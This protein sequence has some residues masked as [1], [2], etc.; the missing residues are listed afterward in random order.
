MLCLALPGSCLTRFANLLVHFCG[1]RVHEF[2]DIF[3]SHPPKLRE[4][5]RRKN[6]ISRNLIPKIP[7][8]LKACHMVAIDCLPQDALLSNPFSGGDLGGLSLGG[9][10][11]LSKL[12]KLGGDSFYTGKMD[13]D[14]KLPKA[15]SKDKFKTVTILGGGPGS[16][17]TKTK[18]TSGSK[19]TMRS[20]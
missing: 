16:S 19:G 11:D 15:T 1:G 20:S 9:S 4:S 3:R 5:G 6:K 12:S 2:V 10:W 17:I 18:T 14:V 8:L 13:M 7:P